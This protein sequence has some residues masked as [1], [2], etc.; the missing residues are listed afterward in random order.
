[1]SSEV[2]HSKRK[3]AHDEILKAAFAR[4]GMHE[5]MQVYRNWQEKN[6]VLVAYRSIIHKQPIIKTTDSSS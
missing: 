2:K 5:V 4:P 1:M 6:Q 3:Q